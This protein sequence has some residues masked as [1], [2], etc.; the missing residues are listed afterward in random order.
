MTTKTPNHNF[1]LLQELEMVARSALLDT[2]R[3]RLPTFMINR[4]LE[5]HKS[6]LKQILNSHEFMTLFP[7]SGQYSGTFNEID[8]SCL[9]KLLRVIGSIAPHKNGWGKIPADSDNCISAH[10][11]RLR[12]IRNSLA[13]N[14][15]QTFSDDEFKTQWSKLQKCIVGLVKQKYDN[16]I[17]EILQSTE[18]KSNMSGNI[19]MTYL[20]DNHIRSKCY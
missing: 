9:C 10:I 16:E 7:G 15:D 8:I 6:N 13:H 3:D 17:R 19:T 5:T 2:L 18:R 1:N 14:P 4:V 11:E 20:S 12:F